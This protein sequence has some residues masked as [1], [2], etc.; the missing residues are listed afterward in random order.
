MTRTL[1]G[2]K[3]AEKL[4]NKDLLKLFR[5]INL[6]YF[7]NAIS[8]P[9][10]EFRPLAKLGVDG[11]AKMLTNELYIDSDLKDHPCLAE[12]VLIHE[13]IHLL[14]GPD[15]LVPHGERFAAE[16]VRLWNAGAFEDIF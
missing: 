13:M 10:I 4:T 9:K 16:K 14:L 8:E 1:T 2:L 11:M 3:R 5:R 15:Y 12:G 7:R 6:K